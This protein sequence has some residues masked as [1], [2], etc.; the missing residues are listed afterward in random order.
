MEKRVK[1]PA[2][3]TRVQTHFEDFKTKAVQSERQSS[4]INNIVARAIKSKQLPVLMNRQHQAG[5]PD[6]ISY[7]EALN[8]VVAADQAFMRL[9]SSVRAEFG[10]DPRQLLNAI[11]NHKGNENLTKK[12]QELDIL[13]KSDPVETPAPPSAPK[14]LAKEEQAPAEGGK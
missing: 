5:L 6:D 13:K 8:K 10:N 12:L 14:T 1:K 7:Q 9:P 11:H 4:D 3:R 2:E